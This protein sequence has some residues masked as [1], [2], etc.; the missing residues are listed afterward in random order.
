MWDDAATADAGPDPAL[1]S[2]WDD[3]AHERLTM[4]LRP[5]ASRG[6]WSGAEPFGGPDL[7]APTRRDGPVVAL[8]RA[9]LRATRAR[10][11]WRAVPPV[12]G[13]LTGAPGLRLAVGVGESPVL[14]QGTL[15]LWESADHL[16]DFAYRSEAHQE[17]VRR[18]GPARWYAE[19]LFARFAVEDVAGTY[20]GRR[21]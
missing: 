3:A 18:T 9:R 15:S 6:R 14:L 12:V 17:A 16:V 2:A 5:Q 4:R 11:F 20:R 21:P 19:E 1:L 13:D 10:S 8:T 7:P